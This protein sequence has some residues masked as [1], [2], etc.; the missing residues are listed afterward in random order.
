MGKKT[1]IEKITKPLLIKY[2]TKNGGYIR[3]M[4]QSIA[5]IEPV[6]V[7][8]C[9]IHTSGGR[10]VVPLSDKDVLQDLSGYKY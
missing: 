8:E 7:K 5:A 4:F 1:G 6:D 3:I 10:F 9:I 2:P